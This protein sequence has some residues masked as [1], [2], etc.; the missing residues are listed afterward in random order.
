VIFLEVTEEGV[1]KKIGDYEGSEQC[2]ES[3][4]EDKTAPKTLYQQF[5]ILLLENRLPDPPTFV[6]QEAHETEPEI[7]FQGLCQNLSFL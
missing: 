2:I 7:P 1:H 5:T 6:K 4:H 3:A